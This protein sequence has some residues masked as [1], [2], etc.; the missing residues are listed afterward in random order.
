MCATLELILT[1][2]AAID[3]HLMA[4]ILNVHHVQSGPLGQNLILPVWRV[5]AEWAESMHGL[6]PQVLV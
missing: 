4:W 6:I 1:R 3:D 2:I 5:W